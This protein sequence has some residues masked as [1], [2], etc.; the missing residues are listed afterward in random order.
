MG[1]IDY[2][3]YLEIADLERKERRENDVTTEAIDEIRAYKDW[4]I[5]A[6]RELNELKRQVR[7]FL[8]DAVNEGGSHAKEAEAILESWRS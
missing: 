4:A 3:D 5:R 1:D 6:E 2:T 7:P 8:M